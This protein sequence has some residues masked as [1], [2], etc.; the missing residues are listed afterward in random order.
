MFGRLLCGGLLAAAMLV[1]PL[2]RAQ[3]ALPPTPQFRRYD[4]TD[5]LPSGSVYDILQDRQ[6]FMWFATASGLARFDG[7]SFKTFRQDPQNPDSLGSS[8][9]H[10]LKLDREGRLWVGSYSDGLAMLLP[11]QQGFRKWKHRDDDPASLSSDYVMALEQTPDGDLW[12][13]TDGGGLDR[14]RPGT[15]SF[16][17]VQHDPARPD[18]LVSDEV[19]ALL[20][21]HAGN[22]W[23]GT[24]AGLDVRRAGGQLQHVP[25][26]AQAVQRD[27]GLQVRSLHEIDGQVWLGTNRGAYRVGA[28][29]IAHLAVGEPVASGLVNGILRDQGGRLWISG[30]HGIYMQPAAGAAFVHIDAAQL[31]P[32][33]LPDSVVEQIWEDHEGG[34]WFGCSEHG[35]AYLPPDWNDFSL[36]THRPDDPDSLSTTAVGAL[37]PAHDG[38]LWVAAGNHLE[39][40]DPATGKI[41]HVLADALRQNSQLFALA[42]DPAG[43][44]L[45][46]AG[47]GNVYLYADGKLSPPLK[48]V[49]SYQ[50]RQ[51]PVDAAGR[52]YFETYDAILRADP[53]GMTL[54]PL[55]G[56]PKAEDVYQDSL[57][58]DALWRA[59]PSGLSQWDF[60]QQQMRPVPGVAAGSVAMF[61]FD[62]DHLWVYRE[63][64]IERYRLEAGKAVRDGGV[65]MRKDLPWFDMVGMH[66]DRGGRLWLFGLSGL[67]RLDPTT[68]QLRSF[69]FGQGLSN[70]E[71]TSY[72]PVTLPDGTVF[73]ATQ[74][75][76]VGFQPQRIVDHL[77]RPR[78]VLVGASVLRGKQSLPL[79]L[80][81]QPW[82]LQWRDRDLRLKVRAL[83]YI[84]P[85]LNHYQF[86]L[87]GQDADW[88]DTDTVGEREFAGLASGDYVLQVRAAGADG[89]WGMLENPLHIHVE[90]P[91]WARWW[92]WLGYVLLL[93]LLVWSVLLA[94]RRRLASRHRIQ[95][96]EQKRV[97]AE[98]ASAAKTQ[99]LATLSHEIRTPMTGVIGMAELLLATPLSP[100]QHE[101]TEA[102]Q[103]SGGLLLKLLNDTLD[104]ARIEAGRLEL[105]PVAFELRRLI[106]DVVRLERARAQAKGLVLE[107]QVA[108]AVPRQLLGDAMRIK[109]ILLNLLSNALKFTEHG[110]VA[111]RVQWEDGQLRVSVS[112]TGPGIPEASQAR[113]F[114]RFEQ[115]DGPQRRAGSG[116]GLAI[117]RELVAMM[118]GSIELVSRLGQGSTFHVRLPLAVVEA[119]Q[120]APGGRETDV[121]TRALELLLVED[122][123]I[124]A[125]VVRGLLEQQG[126]RV[127]HVSN[128]LNALAELAQQR[129]DAALLDLDLPGVDG[130]QIARLIRQGEGGGRRMPIIAVTARSGG[131]EELRAREAGMDDFLRK[132]V[133]GAQLA[134]ALTVVMRRQ[135]AAPA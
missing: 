125:A 61:D 62:A 60:A 121:E 122:D 23:I 82:T 114:Q 105:E 48:G 84:D 70:S 22:L 71:F 21:D 7:I 99:F 76:L 120:P 47:S 77:R 33:G 109:Q 73:A 93:G 128:G 72:D 79:P 124:V 39:K 104:L 25:F 11:D 3:T 130:F 90:A 64:G 10:A 50:Y 6:G 42:E 44:H 54:Q 116:L 65:A 85:K 119:S 32:H 81:G 20:V 19:V 68:G 86:R 4:V 12:V 59:T 69:G 26:E 88:V 9:L 96:A 133:T 110:G 35:I 95:L 100:A 94:W 112:D 52:A 37:A 75:G 14:L 117:C 53:L 28:D 126:H 83:S 97:L 74:G 24:R 30:D 108:E 51:I 118:G 36:F 13:A 15:Q 132:P 56:V 41:E 49:S 78:V 131:D 17:H 127:V 8:K 92:A 29:G 129:Y 103:R 91:P 5:G 115:D 98:Q 111:L 45:W 16:E 1:E 89:S 80:D 87:S 43:R 57:H 38:R 55:P 134:V 31:L 123:S 66:V 135:A 58:G 113:L 27:A 107:W 34:L 18:S 101:Y 2:A 63:D 46:I 102:V 67:W 106:D 40:F